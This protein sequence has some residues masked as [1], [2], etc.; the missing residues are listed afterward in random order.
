MGQAVRYWYRSLY[1]N[2]ALIC[3]LL[4]SGTKRQFVPIYVQS[5]YALKY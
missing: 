2:L 5:F 1:I 3:L 4:I